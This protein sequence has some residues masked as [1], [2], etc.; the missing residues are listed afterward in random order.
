L[1]DSIVNLSS[2]EYLNICRT[3]IHSVPQSV[4]SIKTF[5]DNK[6]IEIIPQKE[7]LSYRGFV[8]C[9]Y[10][11]VKAVLQFNKKERQEGLLELEEEVKP[12]ADDDFYSRGIRLVVDGTDAEVIR[13]ILTTLIDREHDYYRK[14]LMQIALEGILGIQSGE[15]SF[16]I[17]ILLNSMVE[18][19]DN[20]IDAAW[21]KYLAGDQNAFTNID[22]DAAIQPEEEREEIRFVKRAVSLSEKAH[23]EGLLALEGCI[24]HDGIVNKDVFEYGL[25]M[26][27]CARIFIDDVL[28]RLISHETDPVQKNI[29]LAKKEAVLSIHEG[30][31]TRITAQKLCA[32]FDKSIAKILEEELFND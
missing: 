19:K 9:Y 27:E 7:S 23:W 17:V 16:H 24:D 18:I 15:S 5:I 31:N 6:L 25:S 10:K 4:F 1:P 29:A 32:Y 20:P 28:T 3:N 30:D 8:N 22:F 2:L 14:K 26:I 11:L 21:V 13:Q 12:F